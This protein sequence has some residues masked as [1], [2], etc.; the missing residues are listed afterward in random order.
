MPHNQ[1]SKKV[2]VEL[3]VCH[4]ADSMEIRYENG[5]IQVRNASNLGVI[6]QCTPNVN[7]KG[8]PIARYKV[9]IEIEAMSNEP[10]RP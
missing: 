1:I 3:S 10:Y 7:F 6:L 8:I 4:E 5:F 9:K 2:E